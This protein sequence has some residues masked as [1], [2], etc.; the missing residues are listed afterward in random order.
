MAETTPTESDRDA[1]T[2]MRPVDKRDIWR[3][4][5]AL[6]ALQFK[7]I[8]GDER[9]VW[10]ILLDLHS[11]DIEVPFGVEPLDREELL[12]ERGAGREVQ[13]ALIVCEALARDSMVSVRPTSGVAH[14]CAISGCG[15]LTF[16]NLCPGHE[17][18]QGG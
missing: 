10:E 14:P 6:Y 9:E 17:F 4:Y 16:A 8:M 2:E 3:L 5:V 12:G 1:V 18:E 11:G 15:E 13:H 7:A